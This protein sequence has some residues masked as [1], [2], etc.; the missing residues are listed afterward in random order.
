MLAKFE[1]CWLKSCIFEKSL[2][3]FESAASRFPRGS[4]RLTVVFTPWLPTRPMA[5]FPP[6]A[7]SRGVT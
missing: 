3:M 7:F 5:S 4:E 2:E 1:S 6:S